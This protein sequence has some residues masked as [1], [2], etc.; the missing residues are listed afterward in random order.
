MYSSSSNI[1]IGLGLLAPI[2]MREKRGLSIEG[3]QE[4]E[5][6]ETIVY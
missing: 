3:E 1:A 5:N 4:E 2:V 6:G